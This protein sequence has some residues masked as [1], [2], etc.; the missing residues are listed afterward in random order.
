[1]RIAFILIG[2]E[3]YG[4]NGVGIGD[5]DVD[6]VEDE[7]E[8]EMKRQENKNQRINEEVEVEI[9]DQKQDEEDQ[10]QISDNDEQDED[11]EEDEDQESHSDE[12]EQATASERMR[13][14]EYLIGICEQLLG[15]GHWTVAWLHEQAMETVASNLTDSFVTKDDATSQ[16]IKQGVP[17]IGYA[18]RVTRNGL[19]Y[20]TGPA[21]F[22]LRLGLILEQISK[23]MKQTEM[24]LRSEREK[25]KINDNENKRNE[26]R[27]NLKDFDPVPSQDQEDIFSSD[28]MNDVLHAAGQLQ[29]PSELKDQQVSINNNSRVCPCGCFARGLSPSSRLFRRSI[30]PFLAEWGIKEQISE[31]LMENI[32]GGRVEAEKL[33]QEAGVI[34]EANSDEREE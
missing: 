26:N 6:E 20:S 9:K 23:Q 14:L 17:L 16:L 10:E 22:T 13:R 11:E 4:K 33:L 24:K 2:K 31:H 8:L 34:L 27:I 21:Y 32:E 7:I 25:W 1:K 15:K 28:V 18:E 3:D 12:D 5:D 19:D 30:V 29:Q